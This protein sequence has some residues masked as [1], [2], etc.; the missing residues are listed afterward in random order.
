MERQST[1]IR[2]EQIK[3]AVIDIISTHGIKNLSI[4]NLAERIG[5][6]EGS[7]FRHFKSKNDII[8]SIFNDIQDNFI[9]ELGR[10]ARSD[11][12]PSIRLN[13]YLSATIEY[14]TENKGINMLLFSE[15][16][17]KNNPELKKRLQQIFQDQKQFVMEI[18]TDGI[19]TGIW[20]KNVVV[21]NVALIYMG[22]PLAMNMEMLIGGKGFQFDNFCSQ[23]ILLLLKMLKK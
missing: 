11:E 23:M 18:I 12:E 4:K 14:H 2:Q 1:D 21:E 17:Y 16:S 13:K 10:I 3:Q 6:S 9:G 5:M 22:I 7:I 15:A 20:D 19:R 8:I